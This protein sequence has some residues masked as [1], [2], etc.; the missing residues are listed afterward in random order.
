M[1]AHSWNPLWWL[2]AGI[3]VFGGLRLENC[4]V[5]PDRDN[6]QD[7]LQTPWPTQWANNG[8]DE[9]IECT[10]STEWIA[11][12]KPTPGQIWLLFI[13]LLRENH[14]LGESSWAQR[15]HSG[16][17]GG[18]GAKMVPSLT[19]Q[20]GVLKIHSKLGQVHRSSC[21]FG[22]EEGLLSPQCHFSGI[23]CQ[24]CKLSNQLEF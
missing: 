13:S 2:T 22:G 5:R 23:K 10:G 14:K 15:K 11:V 1:V 3:P 6:E 18:P 7:Y 19:G 12:F 24:E 8:S 9:M 4:C 16:G 21:C 17:W 20:P